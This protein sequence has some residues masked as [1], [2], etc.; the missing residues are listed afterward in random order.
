MNDQWY[1][2]YDFPKEIIDTIER[3]NVSEDDVRQYYDLWDRVDRNKHWRRSRSQYTDKLSLHPRLVKNLVSIGV[4]R[5]L[6]PKTKS[7]L[8]KIYYQLLQSM[9]IRDIVI[10]YGIDP[11]EMIDYLLLHRN[12]PKKQSDR[13]QWVLRVSSWYYYKRNY[14]VLSTDWSG[15][16]RRKDQTIGGLLRDQIGILDL[17]DLLLFT[18]LLLF[19]VVILVIVGL[20]DVF[21]NFFR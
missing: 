9:S 13:I 1:T 14:H 19:I 21:G 10:M 3:E 12:L 18:L 5:G 6:D 11:I 8:S 17:K 4:D 20:S 7:H 16:E 2:K 15:R